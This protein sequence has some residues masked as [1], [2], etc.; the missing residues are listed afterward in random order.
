MQYYVYLYLN[1]MKP[2][3]YQYGDNIFE[4]EPIYCGM[5]KGKRAYN[6]LKGN[7]YNPYFYNTINKILKSGCNPLVIFIRKD[8]DQKEAKEVEMSI[9]ECIGRKDL[10]KGPLLNLTD[11]G[12]GKENY[13][14]PNYVKCKISDS[15]KIFYKLN[16]DKKND[17]SLRQKERYN[18]M[19][20]DAFEI[21]RS[22]RKDIMIRPDVREKISKKAI[23]RYSKIENRKLMSEI[24]KQYYI[25]NPE[26]KIPEKCTFKGRRHSE[27][28]KQ[29]MRDAKNIKLKNPLCPNCHNNI[30]TKEK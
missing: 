15:E 9:I 26:H 27:E 28:T 6:H 2:G 4:Y 20:S 11:G 3:E 25:D 10:N 30:W 16:P 1:T 18:C 12:D 24:K 5:G 22:K 14:T 23:E 7:K 19:T 8:I 21:Y 13:I 17:M 29:K